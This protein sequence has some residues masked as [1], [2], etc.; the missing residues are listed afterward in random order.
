MARVEE[1]HELYIYTKKRHQHVRDPNKLLIDHLAHR[2]SEENRMLD[3][4]WL[5]ARYTTDAL[6]RCAL[7]LETDSFDDSNNEFLKVSQESTNMEKLSL[8]FLLARAAPLV[9][10]LLRIKFIG[11]EAEN[12]YKSVVDSIVARKSKELTKETGAIQLM[13]DARD[14]PDSLTKFDSTE[15]AAQVIVLLLGGLETTTSQMCF[16]AHELALNVDVQN[17]LQQEID[18]VAVR[19]EGK[20]SC[21][22][23]SDMPYLDAVLRES[24]RL[25]PT[26]LLDRVCVKEFELPPALPRLKPHRVKPGDSV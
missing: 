24:M 14:R 7:S 1:R 5:F 26:S 23:I 2:S 3:T 4:K 16:M 19:T 15:M 13:L 12:Y 11:T 9:S 10:K 8:K 20:P 22:D 18:E 17:K 6:A 21:K 25:H